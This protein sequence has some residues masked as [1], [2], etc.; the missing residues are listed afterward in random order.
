M[1]AQSRGLRARLD[2]AR[3][4]RGAHGRAIGGKT[5]EGENGLKLSEGV[6]DQRSFRVARP[7]SA[8]PRERTQKRST[9]FVSGQPFF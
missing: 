2:A 7:A 1:I 3:E 8:H 6:H 5:R 9:T 4:A